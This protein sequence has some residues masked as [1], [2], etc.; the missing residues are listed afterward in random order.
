MV[1]TRPLLGRA[2][3]Q[4]TANVIEH[5]PAKTVLQI[6]DV[7]IEESGTV[8]IQATGGGTS[9]PFYI[10]VEPGG[11]PEV[12]ELGR[13]IK[14]IFVPPRSGSVSGLVDPTTIK[15]AIAELKDQGWK[16]TWI[17]VSTAPTSDKAEQ[18]IR[19]ARMSNAEYILKHSDIPLFA[20]KGTQSDV[21]D[22][23][24]SVAGRED[25]VGDSVRIRFF[26]IK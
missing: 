22:R 5:I 23:I 14:E 24:T 1:A 15:S 26:G 18:D 3:P 13:S 19:E 10:K 7:T 17:S 9:L 12:L 11:T 2:K 21:G 20:S 8:W 4:L 6:L 25:S 16:V